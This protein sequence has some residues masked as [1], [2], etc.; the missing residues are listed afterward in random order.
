M[1]SCKKLITY[2]SNA[3]DYLLLANVP[4][5]LCNDLYRMTIVTSYPVSKVR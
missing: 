1:G 4:N 3:V 2:L 5:V